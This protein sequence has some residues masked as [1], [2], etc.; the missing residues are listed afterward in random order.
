LKPTGSDAIRGKQQNGADGR[1]NA[2]DDEGS[3]GG[4]IDHESHTRKKRKVGELDPNAAP[5]SPAARPAATNK[6]P[7]GKRPPPINSGTTDQR[8]PPTP[9]SALGTALASPVVTGFPIH[10]ADKETLDSVGV[11]GTQTTFDD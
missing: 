7:R 3:E 8:E 2:A 1:G 10:A 11:G 9:G 4:P 6:A 5:A